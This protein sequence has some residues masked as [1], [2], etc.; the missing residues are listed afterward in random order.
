MHLTKRHPSCLCFPI[1]PPFGLV[2]N[3]P[4]HPRAPLLNAA[5]ILSYFGQRHP[6]DFAEFQLVTF[7]PLHG[8][9]SN[10]V[11]RVRDKGVFMRGLLVLFV[12]LDL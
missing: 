6:P 2:R 7:L 12:L 10:N 8:V 5:P 3:L 4:R 9:F 1:R 11:G